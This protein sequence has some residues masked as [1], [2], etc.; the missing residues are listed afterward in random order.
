MIQYWTRLQDI[1][2]G[3]FKFEVCAMHLDGAGQICGGVEI[4][5]PGWRQELSTSFP[6]NPVLVKDLDG[7]V[8]HFGWHLFY[9]PNKNVFAILCE[10]T[11]DEL[12]FAIA[13]RHNEMLLDLQRGVLDVEDVADEFMQEEADALFRET[14]VRYLSTDQAAGNE[15][16]H[17]VAE[18]IAK[19]TIHQILDKVF[20]GLDPDEDETQEAL[21]RALKCAIAGSAEY[22]GYCMQVGQSPQMG[23]L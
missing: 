6:S 14:I 4:A 12:M 1:T 5:L 15:R 13:T 17:L 20:P 18:K 16:K 8:E 10:P 3:D 7:C 21:E 9:D 23:G 22:R 19:S 2:I 11:I